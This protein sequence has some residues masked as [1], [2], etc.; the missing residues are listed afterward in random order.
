MTDIRSKI[1]HKPT[2]G[3]PGEQTQSNHSNMQTLWPIWRNG[4][5]YLRWLWETDETTKNNTKATRPIP[6]NLRG[7][8]VRYSTQ[9]RHNGSETTPGRNQKIHRNRSD[10]KRRSQAFHEKFPIT[11]MIR[12]HHA[13]R[14]ECL[15]RTTTKHGKLQTKRRLKNTRLI[16]KMVR[17]ASCASASRKAIWVELFTAK[18]TGMLLCDDLYIYNNMVSTLPPEERKTTRHQI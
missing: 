1:R 16:S 6:T 8:L 3:R 12:Q 11:S 14:N 17:Y 4:K 10:T 9:Q 18:R 7:A 2:K 13:A 15:T 5:T